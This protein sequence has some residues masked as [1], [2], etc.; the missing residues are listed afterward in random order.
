MIEEEPLHWKFICSFLLLAVLVNL[1]VVICLR[2]EN[3]IFN[4]VAVESTANIGVYWDKECKRRVSSIDWGVLSPGQTKNI[5][6]YV[7][8]EGA[9][10]ILLTEIVTDWNPSVCSQYLHLLFSC[11]NR[12]IEAGKVVAVTEILSVSPLVTGV[13]NFTFSITFTH[14]M[15]GDLGGGVPPAFFAFDHVVDAKDLALFIACFQKIAPLEAM[16]LGDLGG[17][18]P[19]TFFAFDGRVD[20]K[21]LTLFL[22][23]YKSLLH[24][25]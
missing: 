25:A 9:D 10:F 11:Q 19:P 18:M 14:A 16:Y 23:L 6:V 15:L 24:S 13:S 2:G 4:A 3:V 21:D 22:S 12:K 20:W 1:F 17:G 8:N 5:T 7:R